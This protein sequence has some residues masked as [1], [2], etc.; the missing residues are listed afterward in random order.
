M[1]W[2]HLAIIFVV[3]ICCVFKVLNVKNFEIKSSWTFLIWK[4]INYVWHHTVAIRHRCEMKKQ[5]ERLKSSLHFGI[6]QLYDEALKDNTWWTLSAGVCAYYAQLH[7]YNY[8]YVK[9]NSS[10]QIVENG[11]GTKYIE[12]VD[13]LGINRKR[14]MHWARVQVLSL[15]FPSLDWVLYLDIDATI[16]PSMFHVPLSWIISATTTNCVIASTGDATDLIFFSNYPVEPH[17]P[18]SGIFMLS[19]SSLRSLTL[20]WDF[21]TD[22]YFDSNSEFDQHAVHELMYYQP[23]GWNAKLLD[24][25][26]FENSIDNSFFLHYSGQRYQHAGHLQRGI[27][28]SIVKKNGNALLAILGSAR[29]VRVLTCNFNASN[30]KPLCE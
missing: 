28:K 10:S 8:T 5:H 29:N 25:R 22:A 18:C 1:R 27:L 23:H 6:V 12:Y 13:V 3:S 2:I 11:T 26:G 24:I 16:N 17:L 15:V 7:G 9:L 19:K 20:W 4:G 14:T 30:P 21:H